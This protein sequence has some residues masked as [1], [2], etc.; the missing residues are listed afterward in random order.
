MK[1]FRSKPRRRPPVRLDRTRPISHP[2]RMVGTD[3]DRLADFVVNRRMELRLERD[4]LADRMEM[5]T[6]TV[7]RIE[8]GKSV[9]RTTLAALERA[10]GWTPGSARRVLDGGDPTLVDAKDPAETPAALPP[11]E[12]RFVDALVELELEP[13][14]IAQAVR[15]Y[16][17]RKAGERSVAPILRASDLD[18]R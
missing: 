12:Q 15:E 14:T 16:R 4:D 17:E 2:C 18:T 11:D 1:Y 13:A 10:L 3:F 8:L 5:V 9:R 7:E 6:K